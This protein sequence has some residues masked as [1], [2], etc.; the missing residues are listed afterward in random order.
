MTTRGRTDDAADPALGTLG[1]LL[2]ELADRLRRLPE[3]R[4]NKVAAAAR[5]LTQTLADAAA[6][7][8]GRDAAEPPPRR[9]VPVLSIFAVADQVTVTAHDLT[10]AAGDLA[11][12]TVVWWQGERRAVPDVLA[13][14]SG[15]AERVRALV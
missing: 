10:A 12:A 5:D 11:P 4:L 15:H 6:G 8:E 1:E 9:V 3:S 2:T 7:I 14:L 13:A